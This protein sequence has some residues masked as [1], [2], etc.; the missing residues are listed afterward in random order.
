MSLGIDIPQGYTLVTNGLHILS[1]LVSSQAFAMQF[2][3]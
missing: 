1:V 3:G 2:F